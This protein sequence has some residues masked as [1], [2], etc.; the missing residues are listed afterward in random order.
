MMDCRL[1]RWLR[2]GAVVSAG[3]VGAAGPVWAAEAAAAAPLTNPRSPPP[4]EVFFGPAQLGDVALS[5]SGRW[6]AVAVQPPGLRRGLAVYDLH[7][8][9]APR[10]I[11]RFSDIDI[12]SFN[13][14]GDGRLVFDLLDAQRGGREQRYYSGLFSLRRDG[15]DLTHHILMHWWGRALP[16]TRSGRKLDATHRL[17]H[18]PREQIPGAETVIVRGARTPGNPQSDWVLKRLHLATGEVQALNAAEPS[19]VVRWWFDS[20]GEPLYAMA[21]ARGLSIVYERQRDAQGAPTRDWRSLMEARYTEEPWRLHS[22]DTQGQLYVTLA[23]GPAGE[24]VL[25]RFNP[26]TGELEATAFVA[27]PGF[28][29]SGHLV[30]EP[31]LGAPTPPLGVRVLAEAETTFWLDAGMAAVQQAVDQRLPGRTNTL[32][33]SHCRDAGR[34]VVVVSASDRHPGEIWLWRGTPEQPT[35]WRRLGVQRPAADPA[36]MA[37]VAFTRFS[38]H[39]GLQVPLWLTLPPA[40][41]TGTASTGPAPAVL[42]VHGGPWVRGGRW[43]WEP[44]AQFLAS[45][46]YVVLMPEFRGSTGYGEKLYRAGWRQWGRAMQDD[47]QTA[48][49]WAVQRGLVDPQRVCIAG[50]SYGGYAT[51]MGLARHPDTYRCGVAWVPLT[52]LELMLREGSDDDYSDEG[53]SEL[54]PLLVADRLAEGTLIQSISPVAQASR[55]RAPVLL[56]WGEKDLR[57]PPAHAEAMRNALRRAGNPPETVSYE[58]EGHGWLKKE[59][60][61]DFARRL[62]AFL[63]RHLKA[64]AVNLDD[65]SKSAKPPPR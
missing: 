10:E 1:G 50:A 37:E 36:H 54:L 35:V 28:D 14:V 24:D 57:T 19:N 38:A 16:G 5:P 6:L 15:T 30:E 32:L 17:E 4:A 61:L 3:M 23:Q 56:A 42:L 9:E 22:R 52:D 25:R 40:P 2:L 45:R 60:H 12:R 64:G 53:R 43:H 34:T 39:D 20:R 48:V 62:E 7:G 59:N 55:I 51:L 46:G 58:G 49:Q 65:A 26:R 29:F 41:A 63:L 13:W 33:C 47:L 18:V 11:A 31:A 27:V 21:R 44:M 8:G